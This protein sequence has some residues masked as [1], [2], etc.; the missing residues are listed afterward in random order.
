MDKW[1]GIVASFILPA[2]TSPFW[3]GDKSDASASEA[4]RI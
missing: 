1:I 2:K 4:N 3:D